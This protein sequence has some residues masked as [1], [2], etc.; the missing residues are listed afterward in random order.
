[1]EKVEATMLYLWQVTLNPFLL[2]SARVVTVMMYHRWS[3]DGGAKY[4]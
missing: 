1:V 2:A 4:I 3:P